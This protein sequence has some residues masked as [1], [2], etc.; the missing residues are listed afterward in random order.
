MSGP[1]TISNRYRELDKTGPLIRG[2][3]SHP[4]DRSRFADGLLAIDTG[5]DASMII[6]GVAKKLGLE[7]FGSC[8]AWSPT[9]LGESWYYD[10]RLEI[11]IADE[12]GVTTL[13]F[14]GEFP[15]DR[16]GVPDRAAHGPNGEA[17]SDIGVIGR[18]LLKYA[19]LSY[20]GPQGVVELEFDLAACPAANFT[21]H[22]LTS[23][24]AFAAWRDR[25][26]LISDGHSCQ[27]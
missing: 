17:V 14:R 2:R 7:T 21:P 20:D 19:K 3:F 18:D 27:E 24:E 26:K 6:S 1:N 9:G 23:A 25:S 10:A 13:A 4:R 12:T 15:E 22:D 5:A 8:M 16:G 11:F